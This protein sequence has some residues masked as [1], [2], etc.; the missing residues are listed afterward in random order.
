MNLLH[1]L[2]NVFYKYPKWN[3]V[4]GTFH[5]I[6][7]NS[8]ISLPAD[9]FEITT[10]A[11]PFFIWCYWNDKQTRHYLHT[12]VPSNCGESAVPGVCIDL[13][14]EWLLVFTRYVGQRCR[15]FAADLTIITECH[16]QLPS[17]LILRNN[18]TTRQ[19]GTLSVECNNEQL[20]VP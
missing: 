10:M 12:W 16:V 13:T 7:C 8:A 19:H 17:H 1:N 5:R 6:H 20:Y 2:W 9:A 15:M 18:T 4:M 14:A 11:T 3:K